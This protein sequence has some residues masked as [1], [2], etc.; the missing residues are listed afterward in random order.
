MGRSETPSDE[1]L[2]SEIAAEEGVNYG[3]LAS[4]NDSAER[5]GKGLERELGG[6]RDMFEN[7]RWMR[8]DCGPHWHRFL[9]EPAC[10]AK[11]QRFRGNS[12]SEARWLLRIATAW[13]EYGRSVQSAE[14]AKAV[15]FISTTENVV[16][17]RV[18]FIPTVIRQR[19]A[20]PVVLRGAS[21]AT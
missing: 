12:V 8:S 21:S 5:R 20:E 10:S 2:G 4:G 6:Y 17:P 15:A 1:L 9:G 13:A 19:N 3:D 18:S 11:I 16:T 14:T 7:I